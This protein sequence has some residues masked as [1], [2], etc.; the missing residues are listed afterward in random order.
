M[1]DPKVH[2]V[3]HELEVRQV[4]ADQQDV[5]EVEAFFVVGEEELTQ[6]CCRL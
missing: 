3:V 6:R 1:G 5:V 4:F 2:D